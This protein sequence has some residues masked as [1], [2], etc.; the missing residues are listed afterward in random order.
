VSHER[1]FQEDTTDAGFLE[2]VLYRLSERCC[3]TLRDEGLVGR[4]VT[5]KLRL[6]DFRT[7]TRSRTLVSSTDCDVEVFAAARAM[8]RG[9]ELPRVSV[10]LI[11]VS[12]SALSAECQW[13]LFSRA[14][15]L[16]GLYRSIDRV[17][18]RY[19]EDAVVAGMVMG[20]AASERYFRRRAHDSPFAISDGNPGCT[21]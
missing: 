2:R 19:G 20:D 4:T 5:L 10:R 18:D 13:G 1:T 14:A 3:R 9:F 6:A 17:R 21:A 8:Q 7:F 15:K 12:V 11:G 16:C